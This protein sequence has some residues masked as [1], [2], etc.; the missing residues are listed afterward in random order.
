MLN[1][2][3]PYMARYN[4]P[5]SITILLTFIAGGA[6][7]ISGA[8][9]ACVCALGFSVYYIGKNRGLSVGVCMPAAV[10]CLLALSYFASAFYAVDKYMAMLGFFRVFSV[11]AFM[12]L[13]YQQRA[14]N[15]RANIFEIIPLAGAISVIIAIFSVGLSFLIKSL[16]FFQNGRLGGFFEY[17]N[18]FALWLL[19]GLVVLAFKDKLSKF[20]FMLFALIVCG[21][22]L[23]LSRSM[24]IFAAG[25]MVFLLIKKKG[26]RKMI[27]SM[28][29]AGIFAGIIIGLLIGSGEWNRLAQ[30]PGQ[31]GEWLS[32]LAYY[33]DALPQITKHPF[34]MGYLGYW[35]TQPMWQSAFYETRFVH[36]SLLQFA[37]DIGILPALILSG[38]GVYM[39]LRKKTPLMEKIILILIFV[40]SLIDIDLEFMA[41]IFVICLCVQPEKMKII[42]PRIPAVILSLLIPLFIYFGVASFDAE[43]GNGA[44][45][46]E[47]Y[48]VYTDALEKQMINAPDL[49]T[50]AV[51]AKRL[52]ERNPYNFVAID[53][54]SRICYRDGNYE[55]AVILKS[56]SLDI[57]RMFSND[58]LEFLDICTKGYESELACGNVQAAEF[59]R[60]K[61]VSIPARIEAVENSLSADA[62]RLKHTPALEIP[63]AAV[64]YIKSLCQTAPMQAIS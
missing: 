9:I 55:L 39:I 17:A 57:N 37:L 14:A 42:S 43:H 25:T 48:P 1:K 45:A 19:L 12:I 31:A 20:D 22:F 46:I 54:L 10:A 33:R 56:K 47:M 50:A 21:I 40:H 11:V 3:K 7:D 34:G 44:L 26:A 64:A 4:N 5:I 63:E 36:S 59:Y 28:S 6:G 53:T 30:T 35:Y 41:L 38:A 32:R 2:I 51:Y 60:Q 58:Y 27:V 29:G 16:P 15:E 8:L 49:D 24:I 23:T 62:Y 52:L 13:L 18:T 61:I